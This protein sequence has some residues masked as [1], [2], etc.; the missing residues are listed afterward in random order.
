MTILK[1]TGNRLAAV[2]IAAGLGGVTLTL[3]GCGSS[4]DNASGVAISPE[5][6][7]RQVDGNIGP[8][9]V[10]SVTFSGAPEKNLTQKVR[11]DGKVSL[12]MIGDVKAA[13]RAVSSFQG[14]L[15]SLY[16]KHLQEPKVVVTIVSA[17]AAV[18]VSGEVLN[19]A[20]IPLDRPLTALAAIME[21]GGFGPTADPRKVSVVRTVKGSH[22]RYNL[23]MND[24][25]SGKA[26]AFYLKPYDVIYVGQRTW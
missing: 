3:L 9:D 7:T 4:M 25:M 17:A 26:A 21:S 8:G 14:S 2:A 24:A 22:K 6:R 10:L 5:D 15:A 18:Y 19:P 13:G 16:A 11:A 23:N 12:P 1:L 20:K